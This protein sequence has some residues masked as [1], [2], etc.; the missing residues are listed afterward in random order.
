[1]PIQFINTGTNPGGKLSL[2]NN[3]NAGN[4]VLSAASTPSERYFYLENTDGIIPNSAA[5]NSTT[6]LINVVFSGGAS[7]C[8][9]GVIFFTSDTS[10]A[11]STETFWMYDSLTGNVRGF[12]D[13]SNPPYTLFGVCSTPC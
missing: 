2:V 8:D 1:M 10:L 6:P 13:A 3:N 4:L 11:P 5:C 7:M 12:G 9:A